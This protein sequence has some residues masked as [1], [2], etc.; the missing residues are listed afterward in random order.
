MLVDIAN[1]EKKGFSETLFSF[2]GITTKA[3]SESRSKLINELKLTMPGQFSQIYDSGS[4]LGREIE[5]DKMRKMMGDE[6]MISAYI[7]RG[8]SEIHWD[9]KKISHFEL[10]K[11]VN[12]LYPETVKLIIARVKQKFNEKELKHRIENIDLELPDS[13]KEHKLPQDRKDFIFKLIFLRAQK[14]ITLIG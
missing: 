4:C 9:G 13:L 11:K 2:L 12:N 10:I 14:L 3:K 5:D 8:D 7:N 6:V 1:K